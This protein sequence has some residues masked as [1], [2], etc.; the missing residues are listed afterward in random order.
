MQK[1]GQITTFIIIGIVI[2]AIVAFFL[3]LRG[4]TTPLVQE[5]QAITVPSD[6]A[7][8]QTFVQECLDKTAKDGIIYVGNR[9]GYYNVP[10]PKGRMDNVEVPYFYFNK[11][12]VNV[13]TIETLQDS[14][15]QYVNANI[16]TCLGGFAPLKNSGYDIVNAS[17]PET[18]TLILEDSVNFRMN[19]SLDIEKNGK[20]TKLEL[21]QSSIQNVDL[22]KLINALNYYIISQPSYENSLLITHLI[23]GA[24]TN[25]LI[26]NYVEEGND[27]IVSFEDNST[28]VTEN[29]FPVLRFALNYNWSSAVG[30]PSIEQIPTQVAVVGTEFHYKINFSGQNVFLSDNTDLFDIAPN[31]TIKFTPKQGDEGDHII[32]ITAGNPYGTENAVLDLTIY[33]ENHPPSVSDQVV[34]VTVNNPFEYYILADDEDLEELNF[35]KISGDSS[36]KISN[37]GILSG[38]PLSIG[39]FEVLVNVSDRLSSNTSKITINVK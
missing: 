34:N 2:L 6:V 4:Q 23:F 22:N 5:Q 3:Y 39:V 32:M 11:T 26:G 18:R 20:A 16:D 17:S 25:N 36:F 9:G 21:F 7:P 35:T 19:Y 12:V 31:G 33:S 38:T 24:K 15:S 13:P 29:N 30:A 8:V 10:S 14:I 37:N 27:F 28:E 1:R